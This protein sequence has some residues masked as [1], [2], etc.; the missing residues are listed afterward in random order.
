[1]S[2]YFILNNIM[3]IIDT[4]T[5]FKEDLILDLR[6][7]ALDKFVDYFIVCEAKFSHS[8][9]KK[10]LNF[11]IKNFEKFKDKIIY[12]V[13]DK[14]PEN[15][16]YKNNHKIEIKRKNSI[17]RINH[18]RDFIKSSLETF[19]PEDIVFYSDNDE[20]PNLTDVNFDKILD[21]IIIFNQKLFYYKFDLLLPNINWYGSKACKLK[22][23]KNI[24]LLRATKNK[25]YPFYRLDTLF[26]DIKHQGVN[27]VSDGGWHFSNLK[28]IEELQRKFLNDENHSEYEAR[29]Y[30]I[31][32]IKENIKNKSIDYNHEAKQD[33]VHRFSSS[34]LKKIN[35]E[36]LPTY[37]KKN[38]EK[39][40]M[41]FD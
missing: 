22:N 17:L 4:T 33:S 27:I 36:L 25:N 31:D 39:Y 3:K 7:N 14:E 19:S 37:I 8:G 13:I 20:I 26:S 35:T 24:D 16:D 10:P 12:I 21:N 2:I 38:F 30:T 28:S 41:W 5:Y 11:N 29:G 1:M 6:F 9:N 23:L 40:K 15:I 34:K 18:Q 32:R